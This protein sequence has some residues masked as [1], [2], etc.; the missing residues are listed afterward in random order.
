[1]RRC[2]SN[3][4]LLTLF[5]LGFVLGGC[6][7]GDSKRNDVPGAPTNSQS[8]AQPPS[9]TISNAD[10]IAFSAGKIGFTNAG[11]SLVPGPEWGELSSGP[12]TEQ[13]SISL[14]V[15]S[16]V[17]RNNGRLI[18]VFTSTSSSDLE[19]AA[20]I[21]ETNVINVT[22]YPYVIKGTFKQSGFFA[23]NGITGIHVSYDYDS[24]TPLRTNHL[25]AHVYLFQNNRKNCIAINYITFSD[26]DSAPVE[27]MIHDTLQIY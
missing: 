23:S 15:L 8:K 24:F 10:E 12:F 21:L 4:V 5:A 9:S 1:M 3:S 25:T 2:I 18:Q 16:G 17:G 14:P 11:I 27:K 22:N 7:P 20:N 6:K 19:T 13:Q 26:M